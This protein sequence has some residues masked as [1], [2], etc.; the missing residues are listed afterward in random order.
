MNDR[1]NVLS[2]MR[3]FESPIDVGRC[4]GEGDVPDRRNVFFLIAL[5]IAMKRAS[6]SDSAHAGTSL[7]RPV[8]S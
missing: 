5:N 7:A 4:H 8:S 6:A 2:T 3:Q 1:A